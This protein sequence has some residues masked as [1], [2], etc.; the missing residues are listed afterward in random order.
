MSLH[1]VHHFF[2]S[3]VRTHKLLFF[4]CV[5]MC[6]WGAQ[7]LGYQGAYRPMRYYLYHQ[8]LKNIKPLSVYAWNKNP[9]VDERHV[10]GQEV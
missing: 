6:L 3:H 9:D 10:R 1:L 4:L 5:C 2:H 7:T 8:E